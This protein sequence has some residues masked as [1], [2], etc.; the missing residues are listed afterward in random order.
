M[1]LV[2]PVRFLLAALTGAM[3]A[4]CAGKY[5]GADIAAVQDASNADARADAGGQTACN[6]SAAGLQVFCETFE[7][8]NLAGG[9]WDSPTESGG[10]RAVLAS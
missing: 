5:V 7:R 6:A 4:G 9:L 2:R 3:A 10:G 8:D 1:T